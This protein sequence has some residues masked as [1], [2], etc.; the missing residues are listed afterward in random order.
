M[1]I[2][3]TQQY[4]R[5]DLITQTDIEF[6]GELAPSGSRQKYTPFIVKSYLAGADLD[7][8]RSRV[9]EYDTLLQRNLADRRD[10]NS[11]RTF[12]Q[13]D[14]YVQ[15]LNG[16]RSG[17]ELRRDAKSEAN[18][19]LDTN[20][21]FIVR[22]K[23]PS[24]SAV[25]GAST[26]WCIA[27]SVHFDRYYFDFL[28]TFYFIQV[29]SEFIKKNLPENSWKI[30]VAVYPSGKLE[31]YDSADHLIGGNHFSFKEVSPLDYLFNS[32]SIDRS[33]FLPV[34]MDERL[35]GL[36]S[37]KQYAG[38]TKH[39][40]RNVTLDLSRKGITRLPENIGDMTRLK[41][42]FLSEN[43]IETIPCSIGRLLGLET[44]HLFHNRI[45]ELPES[46][47]N[48]T[49]LKWLGLSGNMISKKTIRELKRKLPNTRIYFS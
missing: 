20:D 23:S 29:R 32:L 44:L 11:F 2:K 48:M 41:S 6:L 49:G 39:H 10:I 4:V 15:E 31:V 33:L 35:P 8:L 19:I 3:A 40:A 9:M 37:Y 14:N 21:L 17:R 26:K 45:T 34:N 22:P 1:S 43:M 13:F 18:I 25:Y 30:A 24:S 46:L 47:G 27:N 7:L 36:I 5:K 42:L 38:T 16:I 28:V 12:G